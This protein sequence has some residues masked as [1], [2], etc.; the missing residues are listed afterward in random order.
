VADQPEKDTPVTE[1]DVDAS[2]REFLR[3][4]V[5]AAYA[6]PLITTLLVTE[7]TAADSYSDCIEGCWDLPPGNRRILNC[8]RK[9][10]ENR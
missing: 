1:D 4:S 10:R 9:C 8:L 5:Y 6:T 2:R 7:K 3:T